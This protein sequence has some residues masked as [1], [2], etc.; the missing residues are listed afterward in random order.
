MSGVHPLGPMP[1]TNRPNPSGYGSAGAGNAVDP[2]QGAQPMVQL[3]GGQ[4]GGGCLACIGL[5]T[6]LIPR[7]ELDRIKAESFAKIMAHEQAHASAAGAFGGGIHI[8]YDANGIAVGGHVPIMIPELDPANPA[9]SLR[10]YM[11]VR[12]AALAPGA[13]ASG[14]DLSVAAQAAS[15]MGQ[16]Q[17]AMQNKQRFDRQLAALGLSPGQLHQGV[18]PDQLNA[19]PLNPR[20]PGLAGQ[21]AGFNPFLPTPPVPPPG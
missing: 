5:Q 6:G 12:A 17:V 11:Q 20:R 21:N 9:Q 4:G 13:D 3:S 2:L 19:N 14:Q 7:A 8:E 18:R 10:N 16:A 15:L 1:H